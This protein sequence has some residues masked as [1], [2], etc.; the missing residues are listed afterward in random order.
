VI[1]IHHITLTRKQLDSIPESERRLLVLL[2]HAGNELNVLSKL[3]HF[4][5]R[6]G[7]ETPIVQ[8][9]EN[10]QS[11]VL[12]RVL[13]GKIYEC[14]NLMQSAFFRSG[15]SK[16]YQSQFDPDASEALDA[17]KRYFGR[18]NL[19]EKVRNG[20]AFHYSPEQIDAGYQTLADG[21]P[22]E[23]YLAKTNANTLYTFADTIAGRAMIEDIKPG[24]HQRAFEV[25]VEETTRAV[26]RINEVIGASMTI[27]FKTY[28]GGNL[29]AL[30]AKEIEI[31]GAPDSQTISIP[32]FVEI[33]EGN[34]T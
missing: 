23:I 16:R 32:Y 7:S 2:A 33:A 6:P 8:Q 26:A 20:H 9:A 31:E 1:R 30:G 3:F 28:L 5:A 17:L 22:L 27:C 12:G 18:D 14:W 4:S 34:G 24:D 25:L 10:T 19:I 13:T 15:L 29:Y 11:M 21:D